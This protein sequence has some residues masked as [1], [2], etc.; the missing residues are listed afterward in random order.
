MAYTTRAVSN[1]GLIAGLVRSGILT[2]SAVKEAMLAVDRGLFSAD[3][4][5]A[6]EDAPHSIGQGQT[7]SAP[8]MHCYAL[9]WCWRHNKDARAILDVGAGSGYLVA[10]L[11]RLYPNS[12][13][14]GIE[15]VPELVAK[16]RQNLN[17][18]DDSLLASGK[19]DLVV[20]NGW[21]SL[22]ERKFDIIHVGAAAETV[23]QELV[24]A[25]S[26]GGIMIIPVGRQNENQEILVIR[27]DAHGKVHQDSMMGVRYV[28]LVKERQ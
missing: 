21:K 18:F 15:I 22:N 11:S 20:G 28:P 14:L 4:Q 27:K 23:P 12:H 5:A 26:P 1:E 8:H 3:G 17:Q 10:A 24:S 16:A 7:I 13:V 6:Y 2:E 25:M 19:V 9:Q